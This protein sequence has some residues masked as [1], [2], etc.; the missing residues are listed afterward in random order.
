MRSVL[1]RV[2]WVR[3]QG[4]QQRFPGARCPAALPHFPCLRNPLISYTPSSSSSK[5]M[6]SHPPAVSYAPE[7]LSTVY[8]AAPPDSRRPSVPLAPCRDALQKNESA[9]DEIFV[10]PSEACSPDNQPRNQS[11]VSRW[12]CGDPSA[13]RVG[14]NSRSDTQYRSCWN[15]VWCP[16]FGVDRCEAQRDSGPRGEVERRPRLAWRACQD[17]RSNSKLR[18]EPKECACCRWTTVGSCAT[19]ARLERPT[20]ALH[21]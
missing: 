15:A 11:G 18:S 12:F 9:R 3:G 14:R 17:Q 13:V 7:T 19:A 2:N 10:R 6:S 20:S 1:C 4:E 21:V 5:A 8:P 16:L